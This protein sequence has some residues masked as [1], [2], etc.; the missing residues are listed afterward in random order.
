M[1]VVLSIIIVITSIALFGQSNF[2]RSV[3]LTDTT[4]TVALS[5]REMQSLGL[6]SRK[7][8]TVQNAGYGGYFSATNRDSYVLFA[9]TYKPAGTPL[10]NCLVGAANTPEQKPGD[11]FYNFGNANPALNDG[12][13][14]TYTFTRGFIV[15]Q[16]CG[17]EGA[18]R[19]CS[20]LPGGTPGAGELSE[21]NI[22]FLRSSTEAAISGKRD[23]GVSVVLT[24]AEIYIQSADGLGTRGICVSRIGQISVAA[25][26]CP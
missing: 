15:R 17:Y 14:Q 5:L 22:S 12:I 18:L 2:N 3:L 16:F 10:S 6:S 24:S 1:M 20:P 11:C 25:G 9:D 19:R 26:T 21:I 8:S 13:V 7:F 23:G 4:Y